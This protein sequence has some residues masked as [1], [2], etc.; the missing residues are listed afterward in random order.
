MLERLLIC[1][2][3]ILYATQKWNVDII[4]M[5]F[6]FLTEV[7]SIKNAIRKAEDHKN[8]AIVIFAAAANDGANKQEMF[9]ASME[10]VIS[11][12]ATNSNG[13]FVPA[14][15]PPPSAMKEDSRLY[16]T[17]GEHV[18]YDWANEKLI[19]SGCSLATPIMAGIT[20]LIMEY[21]AYKAGRFNK[22]ED[23][24]KQIRT[25]RGVIQ[26][27]KEIAIKKGNQRFYVAPWDLFEKSEENRLSI[28]ITA[29]GKLPSQQIRK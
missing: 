22:S 14:Y 9:P 18:P 20:A 10:S 4:S 21:F 16:G 15:D 3:A 1:E 7:V 23:I 19:K 27:F 11:V 17:L 6:G 13:S 8:S 26:L 29:L 12:R 25:Q 28:A 24:L 5:S 2:Q